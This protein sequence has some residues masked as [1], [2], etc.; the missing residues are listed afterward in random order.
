MS[1]AHVNAGSNS[2]VCWVGGHT[3]RRHVNTVRHIPA[4]ATNWASV[5]VTVGQRCKLWHTVYLYHVYGLM[6]TNNIAVY[7]IGNDNVIVILQWIF[8]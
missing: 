7:V 4:N 6:T 2:V 8:I 3:A 1:I 5:G